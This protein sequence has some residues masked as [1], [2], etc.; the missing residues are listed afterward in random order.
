MDRKV[1]RFARLGPKTVYGVDIGDQGIKVGKKLCKKF[2]LK[3]VVF[4]KS[5]VLKLP[6]KNQSFDFVFCKVFCIIL[7]IF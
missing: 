3:N 4:K 6:F 5:S 2:K 7:A 1:N